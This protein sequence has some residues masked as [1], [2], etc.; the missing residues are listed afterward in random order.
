MFA[1]SEVINV[2]FVLTRHRCGSTSGDSQQIDQLIS[3][4][5]PCVRLAALLSTGETSLNET[6]TSLKYIYSSSQVTTQVTQIQFTSR[7]EQSLFNY[8]TDF[9]L[10]SVQKQ[11]IHGEYCSPS[12]PTLQSISWVTIKYMTLLIFCILISIVS[13][14]SNPLEF[15]TI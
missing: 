13:K 8:M 10:N 5:H 4:W 11:R 15:L 6:Q 1:F 12:F 14:T 2:S 9:K 7:D 3:Q